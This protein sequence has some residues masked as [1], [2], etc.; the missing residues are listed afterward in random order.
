VTPTETIAFAVLWVIL[1]CLAVLVLLLYKQLERAYAGTPG[2]NSGLSAGSRVPDLEVI[3]STGLSWYRFPDVD[4][5]I[6]AAFVSTT[7]A[8]CYDLLRTLD[9]D[10]DEYRKEVFTVGEISDEFRRAV[11]SLSYQALAHPYDAEH[12]LGLTALPTLFLVGRRVVLGTTTATGRKG[13]QRFLTASL[14]DEA[15][16]AETR[17]TAVAVPDAPR[18]LG[19]RVPDEIEG[20]PS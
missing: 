4:D 9:R 11:G 12:G 17:A 16:S 1:I 13:I 2:S 5:P 8:G 19:G 20:H 14:D 3:N 7:C 15:S 6:L 10:V 18:A